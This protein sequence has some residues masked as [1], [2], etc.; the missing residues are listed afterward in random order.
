MTSNPSET[1]LKHIV[2]AAVAGAKSERPGLRFVVDG[3]LVTGD[4]ARRLLV[5]S[6][7]HFHDKGSPYCCGEPDCH[8]GI[9]FSPRSEKVAE[10]LRLAL[11]LSPAIVI[12]FDDIATVYYAGVTF[13]YRVA[14]PPS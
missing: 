12:E 7:L 4:P 8:L 10:Q 9:R 14:R 2:E 5:K 11:N 3:V 1:E 13:N 6:T